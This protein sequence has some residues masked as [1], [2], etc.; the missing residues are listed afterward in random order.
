MAEVIDECVDMFSQLDAS[1]DRLYGKPTSD[2]AFRG[3]TKWVFKSTE[4]E[5]LRARVDSMK[6][7][8][9]LMMTLQSVHN[10]WYCPFSSDP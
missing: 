10:T 1:N 4:L 7:N 6:I 9:L 8:I 3:K 5:Y 2:P